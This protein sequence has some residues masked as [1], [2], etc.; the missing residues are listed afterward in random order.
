MPNQSFIP[1]KQP[2]AFNSPAALPKG[3]PRKNG[4]GL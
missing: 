2:S 4:L 3:K 1:G